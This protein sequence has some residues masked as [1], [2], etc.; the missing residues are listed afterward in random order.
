MVAGSDWPAGE[1]APVD[2][3]D[4]GKAR[5]AIRVHHRNESHANSLCE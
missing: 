3:S 1:K 2:D 5:Y 4:A